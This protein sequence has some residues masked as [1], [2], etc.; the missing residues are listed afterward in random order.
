MVRILDDEALLPAIFFI[1]SRTGCEAAVRHCAMSQLRLTTPQEQQ[2]IR[3]VLDDRLALIGHEDE[4]VLGIPQFQ[5][6]AEHGFAAHH[7]GML[8]L[9]KGVVEELFAEGL[10]KAVF[11]TE[12]LSLG[13]NMPARSVVLEKLSKFNGVEHADLT[14]GEYTQLTGRAGR[15]GIDTEGHA[16]VLA[17]GGFDPDDVAALASRRTYPLRSAFRPT[18]NM[19]VNLLDRFDAREARESLEMSFAQFQ[20]DRSVVGLARRAREL[21]EAATSYRDA[22]SCERGDVL[23]YE[24]LRREIAERE[25]TLSRE[26]ASR[27][28]DRTRSVL[29]NL[30]PGD[31][32]A[33]PGGR[34]QGFGVVIGVDREQLK[35]PEVLIVDTDGRT[36]TI[37][38]GD[39][40]G[41]PAVIGAMKVPRA[42]RLT[43]ARARKDVGASLREHLAG[44]HQDPKQAVRA[45]ARTPSTA[46]T[47]ERLLE[48]R[49]AQRSHPCHTCPDIESHLRWVA[50]LRGVEDEH[51]TALRRI[52]GRTSS[53]A[54]QFDRIC[55]LLTELR[56]LE[57]DPEAGTSGPRPTERGERLRWVFSERDLLIAQCLETG[58]WT[59]LDA[60]SLAA[61]ASCV[62]YEPRRAD[63]G[64]AELPEDPAFERALIATQRLA[65]ALNAAE[66]RL[67]LD[68]TAPPEPGIAAVMHRWARGEHY[69]SAVGTTGLPAGDF[70]RQ[71]RQVIDLLDQITRIPDAAPAARAAIHAVRRGFVSQ[72]IDR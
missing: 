57:T 26:R 55:S 2:A 54:R 72:E 41:P 10:I 53:L 33:L 7:A 22:I 24:A 23:A 25:K 42:D 46:A 15:R 58:A 39:V 44:R 45:S 3:A 35:G 65:D 16:V 14:P 71:C 47:D 62:C 31:V 64:A 20:T 28:R 59:G 12:T 61:I 69:A 21:E 13:I 38:P 30:R 56:Y 18:Y 27:D 1:F 8:P 6:A 4:E 19:T 67:G 34:R 17:A 51:R 60:A 5:R 68:V 50:R 37:R 40:P 11:A 32:I 36:R 70:V 49:E 29:R 48:L 52:E 43:Q 63:D 9:L 66:R